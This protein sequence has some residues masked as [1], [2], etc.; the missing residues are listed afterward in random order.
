[1]LFFVIY[2]NDNSYAG[3]FFSSKRRSSTVSTHEQI[4]QITAQLRYRVAQEQD[5]GVKKIRVHHYRN[6]DPKDSYRSGV[7]REPRPSKRILIVLNRINRSRPTEIF[8]I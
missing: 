2:W 3:K 1:M 4:A 6:R 8:L 5:H 7:H